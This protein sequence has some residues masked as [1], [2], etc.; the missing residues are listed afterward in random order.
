MSAPKTL[1]HPEPVDEQTESPARKTVF[2]AGLL[3]AMFL[4]SGSLAVYCAWLLWRGEAAEAVLSGLPGGCS[5]V[6]FV[7]KPHSSP[8]VAGLMAHHAVQWTGGGDATALL[9]GLSTAPPPEEIDSTQAIA[10]CYRGNWWFG[11][12]VPAQGAAAEGAARAFAAW[13]GQA[14]GQTVG[15]PSGGPRKGAWSR[16]VSLAGAQVLWIARDGGNVVQAAWSPSASTPTDNIDQADAAMDDMLAA[17]QTRTLQN[18]ELFRAALERSGGGD[19][20]T[21]E[22]GP[23]LAA[24]LGAS[25]GWSE[26]ASSI[27]WRGAALRV[28]GESLIVHE[29][30]GGGQ[31]VAAWLKRRFDMP[32]EFDAARVLPAEGVV[33]WGVDRYSHILAADIDLVA[34][35]LAARRAAM[36]SATAATDKAWKAALVGP[37]AW[38]RGED[39]CTTFAAQVSADWKT[40]PEAL[41]APVATASCRQPVRKWSGAHLLAG[42]PA[43]VSH[44]E[45]VLTGSARS[46]A[47]TG[48]SR[49]AQRMASSTNGWRDNSAKGLQVL[50]WTWVD[51]GIVVERT[52]RGK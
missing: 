16:W 43:G 48:L 33:A 3:L 41:P 18:D 10:L 13:V 5:R 6:L 38:F 32:V 2:A 47:A 19:V 37:V 39:G 4:L 35:S 34:M 1:A 42:S 27:D 36:P 40:R 17:M 12:A 22:R 51:T 52:Y 9:K 28:E 11:A 29:H 21:F 26:T 31:R 23:P 49:D 20:H 30:L 46:L 14:L 7:D 44:L 25:S 45:R 15:T 50:E 24:S 8:A